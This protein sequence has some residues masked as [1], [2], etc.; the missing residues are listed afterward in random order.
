M[1]F[2]SILHILDNPIIQILVIS[3]LSESNFILSLTHFFIFIIIIVF[4][5]I[6]TRKS[7]LMNSKLNSRNYDRFQIPSSPG[8]INNRVGFNRYL[9][10]FWYH[11]FF[12]QWLRTYFTQKPNTEVYFWANKMNLLENHLYSDTN[13]TEEFSYL[14]QTQ[15]I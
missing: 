7:S 5:W 10:I 1:V 14:P 3:L 4:N 15:I 6:Q 8:I 12:N 2:L 13:V 9:F 11:V